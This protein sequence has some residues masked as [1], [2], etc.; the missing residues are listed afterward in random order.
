MFKSVL[1]HPGDNVAVAL[2]EIPSGAVVT[3]LGLTGDIKIRAQE[4]IA[5]AHKVAVRPIA[6]G[7]PILKY[8]VPIAVATVDISAGKWVHTHNATTML[9][10]NKGEQ[11]L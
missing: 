1:I 7:G 4:A 3:L 8:G 2:D 11:K 5:F 6:A 10:S 9:A